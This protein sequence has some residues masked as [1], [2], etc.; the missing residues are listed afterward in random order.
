MD[1]MLLPGI[2]ILLISQSV[3]WFVILFLF[4]YVNMC[5]TNICYVPSA[6]FEKLR[7]IKTSFLIENS[8]KTNLN[9]VNYHY[10]PPPSAWLND[11][12]LISLLL[13]FLTSGSL[14][15]FYLLRTISSLPLLLVKNQ[16]FSLFLRHLHICPIGF[17]FEGT[18]YLQQGLSLDP[19]SHIP[20]SPSH[21]LLPFIAYCKGYFVCC[22]S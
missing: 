4:S 8:N 18:L 19:W 1:S 7:E 17:V 21:T 12:V 15:S 16:I 14:N 10:E 9:V 11:P 5:A 22:P 3:N 6:W 20:N 2:M 13:W